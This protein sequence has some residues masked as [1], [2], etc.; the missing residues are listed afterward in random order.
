MPLDIKLGCTLGKIQREF[1]KLWTF[2]KSWTQFA[3]RCSPLFS[4][5]SAVGTTKLCHMS[6]MSRN[7]RPNTHQ[8]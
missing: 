1:E 5:G 7:F 4:E 6:I 2:G 8:P 3:H